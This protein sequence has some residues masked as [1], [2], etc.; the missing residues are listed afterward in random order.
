M[1]VIFDDDIFAYGKLYLLTQA[2]FRFKRSDIFA[3]A[4][5]VVEQINYMFMSLR[6]H[7]KHS[8]KLLFK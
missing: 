6:T 5:V 8:A 7:I 2:I 4:N 3:D 1:Y